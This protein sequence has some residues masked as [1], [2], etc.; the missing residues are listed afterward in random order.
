MPSFSSQ[1][2]Y[3]AHQRL[4]ERDCGL[5]GGRRLPRLFKQ[6]AMIDISITPQTIILS[7][8]FAELLLGGHLTRAQQAG[9]VS[10]ADVERWWTQLRETHEAGTFFF[11]LTAL[12]VAGTKS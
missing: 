8:P 5:I 11:G 2:A 7:Y 12:I 1:R 3:R 6:H 4:L 10:S 9:V